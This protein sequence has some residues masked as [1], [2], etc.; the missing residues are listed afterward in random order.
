MLAAVVTALASAACVEGDEAQT[1]QT[2]RTAPSG[3]D[4][5]ASTGEPDDDE[6]AET[7]TAD[8]TESD[9]ASEPD[10][11]EPTDTTTAESTRSDSATEPDETSAPTLDVVPVGS[12]WDSAVLYDDGAVPWRQ[13]RPHLVNIGGEL[14]HIAQRGNGSSVFRSR[15]GGASWAEVDVVPPPSSGAVWITGIARDQTGRYAAVA[16]VAAGCREAN[17][18]TDPDGYRSVQKCHPM[19][20]AVFLSDDGASWRR[21]DPPALAGSGHEISTDGIAAGPDGFLISGTFEGPDWRAGVWSSPEGESWTLE[22]ELRDGDGLTS[23]GPIASDGERIVLLTG[24]ARCVTPSDTPEAGWQISTSHPGGGQIWEGRSVDD[25]VLRAPGEHPFAAEPLFP[26]CDLVNSNEIQESLPARPQIVLS[27]LDDEIVMVAR[28]PATAEELAAEDD[29]PPP[30]T[31]RTVAQLVGGEWSTTTVE[32]PVRPVGRTMS[33]AGRLAGELVLVELEYQQFNGTTV[34]TLLHTDTGAVEVTSTGVEGRPS[35]AFAAG[36]RLVVITEADLRPYDGLASE[37]GYRVS[38]STETTPSAVAASCDLAAGGECRFTEIAADSVIDGRDL[39]GADL[40]FSS[41]DHIDLDGVDFS[42]S[43][44]R[45]ATAPSFG[46]TTFAGAIF[47]GADLQGARLADL[48]GADLA[49]ADV[50]DA[51]L[52][53]TA[54]PAS[55]DGALV[56]GTRFELPFG[57]EDAVEWSLAGL[58]LRGAQVYGRSDNLLVI[59]SVE[60]A[61]LD[62]VRFRDVDLRRIDPSTVDLSAFSVGG[63]SICPDGNPQDGSSRGTCARS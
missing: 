3:S 32:G 53:F 52:T 45:G 18:E 16:D 7:T 19:S 4:G 30:T 57:H 31:S 27:M 29:D 47:F 17:S 34:V 14:W 12:V 48:A 11:V 60:G 56:D 43:R 8:A 41:F 2:D 25:L 13:P 46:E 24:V 54:P 26:D 5:T 40:S 50:R 62:D 36:G 20:G 28:E 15:D 59:T 22:R 49:G 58:D 38:T 1:E 63:D 23:A 10:D 44:L 39:S 6:P 51:T 37:S 33:F 9:P 21:V 42:F 35:A 61:L 55:L